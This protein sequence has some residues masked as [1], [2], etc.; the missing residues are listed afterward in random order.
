M[1]VILDMSGGGVI[2]GNFPLKK[3]RGAFPPFDITVGG[4]GPIKDA[5]R[6]RGRDRDVRLFVRS[7]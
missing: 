3:V 6:V 2:R 4:N 5:Y 1:G 7:A